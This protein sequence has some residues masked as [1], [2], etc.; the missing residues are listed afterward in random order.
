MHIL[1]SLVSDND[2]DEVMV[3]KMCL[4]G[5]ILGGGDVVAI[6]GGIGWGLRVWITTILL[7]ISVK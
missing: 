5:L 2:D 1:I 7:Q 4:F 3:L 6:G